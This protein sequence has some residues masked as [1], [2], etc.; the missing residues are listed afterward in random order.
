MSRTS[1]RFFRL[2]AVVVSLLLFVCLPLLSGCIIPALG[3]GVF[4]TLFLWDFVLT[5]VRSFLGGL[6]LDFVN[7]I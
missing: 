1:T 7:S 4:G 6:A 2:K 3:A 5:P